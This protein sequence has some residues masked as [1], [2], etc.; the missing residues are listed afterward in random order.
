M[1]PRQFG[2]RPFAS[3][4]AELQD[5]PRRL[6]KPTNG[7]HQCWDIVGRN[8][9]SIDLVD[10]NIA[11]LKCRNLSQ[12]CCACLIHALGASLALRGEDMDIR[13]PE[14]LVDTTQEAHR[15]YRRSSESREKRFDLLMDR[16]DESQLRVRER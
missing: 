11:R 2:F 13:L 15:I 16:A 14:Y 12:P 7:V 10:D 9:Q 6:V 3:C 8:D 4:P 1:V 5:P